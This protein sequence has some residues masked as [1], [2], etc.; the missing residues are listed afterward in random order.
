M[1]CVAEH[2]RCWTSPGPRLRLVSLGLG[3]VL[4]DRF[5]IAPLYWAGGSLLMVAGFLGLALFRNARFEE[6]LT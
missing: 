5:G 6:Q 1:P 2:S 3:G 4:V